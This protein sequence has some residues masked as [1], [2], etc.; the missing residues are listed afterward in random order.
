MRPSVIVGLVCQLAIA[1]L[2]SSVWAESEAPRIDPL[3]VQQERLRIQ[4]LRLDYEAIDQQA[5][6]ACYQKFAVTDCLRAARAKKRVILDDLRRQEV[7]LNDLDRQ[8]KAAEALKRIEKKTLGDADR[9]VENSSVTP[10]G[11]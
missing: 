4:R 9:R 11:H 7:N 8:Y 6:A 2:A 5:Q 1:V 10:A 3:Q